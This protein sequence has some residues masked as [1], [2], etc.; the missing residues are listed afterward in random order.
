[1]LF[2]PFEKQFYLPATAVKVGNALRRQAEM[3]GQKDQGLAFGIFDFYASDR[4]WKM[5]QRI[6]AR[7]RSQL[8]AKDTGGAVC[9]LG[10]SSREARIGLGSRHKETARLVQAMQSGKVEI[11][12]IHDIERPSLWN[13]L[14]ENV[15]VVQLAIADMDETGDVAPQIE[16]RVQF[17]GGLGLTKRRPVKDR[18]AQIDGGRI[19]CVNR[20]FDFDAKRFV[21]IKR[22]G[23]ANQTLREIGINAPVSDRIRIGQG[24]ARYRT[25]KAHVVELGRL[26]PQAGFDVA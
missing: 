19:Q 4:R 12:A 14:V 7:Q 25:A 16:Q 10:V 3:I 22:A 6:K 2:D 21:Q 17:D 8:I 5:L 15:H 11:A 26:T 20:L 1:M 13:N 9:R 24:V 18:Q 23:N